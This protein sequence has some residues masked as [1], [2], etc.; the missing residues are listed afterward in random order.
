L[1]YLRSEYWKLQKQLDALERNFE[2]KS[3]VYSNH[4]EDEKL[5]RDKK[6]FQLKRE[7]ILAEMSSIDENIKKIETQE[8]MERD[9]AHKREWENIE[10]ELIGYPQKDFRSFFKQFGE[11]C[12]RLKKPIMTIDEIYQEIDLNDEILLKI[13]HHIKNNFRGV[14]GISKSFDEGLSTRFARE[15]SKI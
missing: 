10:S 11:A 1:D 5:Q 13:I 8:K 2:A 6:N 7:I 3:K 4:S 15:L 12:L 9:V 14:C